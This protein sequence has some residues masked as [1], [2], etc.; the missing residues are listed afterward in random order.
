MLQ[1]KDH[2]TTHYLETV[3]QL[4]T[5]TFTVPLK[6]IEVALRFEA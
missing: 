3:L 5:F 1:F 4:H 2:T 6:Q